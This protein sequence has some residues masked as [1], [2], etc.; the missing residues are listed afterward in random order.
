MKHISILYTEEVEED[1]YIR[2]IERKKERGL[3][4]DRH[5]ERKPDRS[6]RETK[7]RNERGK[8]PAR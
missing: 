2:Y 6:W 8:E 3:L 7:R 4:G 1:L 5:E